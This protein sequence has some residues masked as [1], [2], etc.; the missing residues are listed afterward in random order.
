MKLKYEKINE[1]NI[2]LAAKI[3]LEIFPNSSA[4]IKYIEEIYSK[5]DL[6]I[7]FLVFYKNN[8]IGVVGLYEQ[9]NDRN[10]IWLSWFGLLEK[11]RNK[12]FGKQM[13]YDIVSIAKRYNKKYLRLYTYENWNNIAQSFYKKHMHYEEYY[14]N[15]NDSQYDIKEGICK[16]FSYSLLGDDIKPWNNKYIGLREDDKVHEESVKEMIQ[17]GILN[18]EDNN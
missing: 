7:D 4:Y 18:L 9:S 1:K 14:T 11:Y 3:Q 12:G 10:S 2:N 17:I 13:F 8:V 5:K 6:P 15:E 16:I